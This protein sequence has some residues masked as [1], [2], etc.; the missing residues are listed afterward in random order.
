MQSGRC[1]CNSEIYS[2]SSCSNVH[3]FVDA[4]HSNELEVPFKRRRK[5]QNIGKR[6]EYGVAVGEAQ[7][8]K[9]ETKI[10][11]FSRIDCGRRTANS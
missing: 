5:K 11:R 9:N 4:M 6:V 3:V 7:H 1:L 2:A 10:E 8:E